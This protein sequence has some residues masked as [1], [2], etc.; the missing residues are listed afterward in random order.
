MEAM[1][2]AIQCEQSAFLYGQAFKYDE[3]VW[4]GWGEEFLIASWAFRYLIRMI[5]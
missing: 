5:L 3:L 4:T 1:D 2:L